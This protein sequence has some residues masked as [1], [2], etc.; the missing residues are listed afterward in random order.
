MYFHI[1]FNT[2]LNYSRKCAKRERHYIKEEK[3]R[4][5][6]ITENIA[7][8]PVEFEED[9]E[10]LIQVTVEID[11]V[12]YYTSDEEQLDS[13]EAE[14]DAAFRNNNNKKSISISRSR[15]LNNQS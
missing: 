9:E 3:K 12:V 1:S 15:T 6:A 8:Y 7:F 11:E 10:Q 2:W 4:V 5:K 13:V 14:E